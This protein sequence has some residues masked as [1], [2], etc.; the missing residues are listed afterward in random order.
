M[1]E[2][3]VLLNIYE[4]NRASH[5]KEEEDLVDHPERVLGMLSKWRAGK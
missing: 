5:L 2:F 1:F 4:E 3:V